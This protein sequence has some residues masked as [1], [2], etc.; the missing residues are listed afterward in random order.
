MNPTE[1]SDAQLLKRAM[2]EMA[3]SVKVLSE[4]SGFSPDTIT[5]F[6]RGRR[7]VSTKL[8]KFLALLREYRD[9]RR[10]KLARAGVQVKQQSARS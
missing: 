7:Q 9:L 1:E 2:K 8:L 6:R 4:I 10:R 3:L 5:D